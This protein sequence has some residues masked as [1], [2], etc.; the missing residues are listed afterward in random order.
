ML[1]RPISG[2][3]IRWLKPS[4]VT[5][6]LAPASLSLA[7]TSTGTIAQDEQEYFSPAT[8]EDNSRHY[9][10]WAGA[11]AAENVWLLY[12]GT[13]LAPFSDMHSDGPRLRFVG[14]YGSYTYQSFDINSLA[15]SSY[16]AN[17]TFADALVG[18][19]W[20]LDPLIVKLFAGA[21]FVDHQIH[22]GDP[23]NKVQGPQV[24][25]K[26]LAELWF[27]IGENGFASF[28]LSWSQSHKSRS[29]R[30][31]IG[32]KVT[33]KFSIGPEIG[34]NVD[35][36]GDY[37]INEEHAKFR[38][39]PLDYGR[40]GMFARYQWDGGEIGVSAGLLGDFREEKSI[41]GT[42]NWITQF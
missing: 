23:N 9:E 5:R 3:C 42:V 38:T 10:V 28:N 34:I 21:S 1:R 7:I 40:I 35:R 13:T 17:V 2:G 41:Y 20:R 26:G 12:S 27:N 18:Y 32:Y 36:Q 30:A 16:K 22:P 11:D 6:L 19:L 8:Q 29:A 25:L 24:G 37:K 14:G 15:V 31:R 33:P 4:W 39:E